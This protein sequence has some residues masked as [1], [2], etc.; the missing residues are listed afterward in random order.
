M[1]PQNVSQNIQE[2][3]EAPEN[4]KDEEI[5]EFGRTILSG[6]GRKEICLLS[7]IGEIEGHENLNSSSKTTKYEH[8][9]P[10][11]A[12]IEDSRDIGG[13]LLLINTQGG[14][15]SCGLALA[16]MVASLSKPTVSLVIGDSH[17]IG[18]PLAVSADASFIVP[19]ATMLIHPVRM[20]GLTI[21]APQTYHYFQKIQDRITGFIA[22]HSKMPQ[23]KIEELMMNTTDLTRDLGTLLVGEEAV[24]LGLIDSM[25]GIRQAVRKLRE[26]MKAKN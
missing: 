15:V 10:K 4:T 20:S 25:G 17:S 26:M 8:V 22:A 23:D 3:R 7:V 1:A 13:V 24:R 9:L 16:E 21:G 18:V 2:G 14:D 12:Q 6:D 11:L 19:T 5:R